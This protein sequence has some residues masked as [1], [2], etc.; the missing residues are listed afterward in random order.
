MSERK[1]IVAVVGPTASGK[2][3]L[4]IHLASQLG[5]EVISADSRQI[6]TDLNIGTEKVTKEEMNGVPHHL[7]DIAAPMQT[8]S[9]LEYS[10][11]AE[12]ALE[13]IWSNG[14]IPFVVGGSGFY[15]DTLLRGITLPEVLPNPTLRAKLEN[16]SLEELLKD[17]EEKDL[18]TFNRIDKENKRRVVRAL[19]IVD[20][21]GTVP[22]PEKKELD[23]DVLW[24]GLQV[25]REEIQ[26]KI[27]DRFNETLEKG[28]VEEVQ[29]LLE[30]G[31][32]HERLFELGLEY[33]A[34][35]LFLQGKIDREEMIE[36]CKLEVF[37]YAKRQERWFKRNKDIE[38][39][40]PTDREVIEKRVR[41]FL[42]K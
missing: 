40:S 35:S 31:V 23:F 19:E 9:V 39:F 38:W 8:V 17:L 21:L 29:G 3:S 13:E 20:T 36:Q 32:T 10:T 27:E 28:L 26:K 6:Y 15:T 12:K 18:D 22:K 1:K 24:I 41:E 33:R 5:G 16:T 42:G 30:K 4:G 37:K 34:V 25:S 2:T 11:L 14:H 7:L